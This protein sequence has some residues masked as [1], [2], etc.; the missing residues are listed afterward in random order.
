[1]DLG[2]ISGKSKLGNGGKVKGCRMVK[3]FTQGHTQSG[4]MRLLTEGVV[5]KEIMISS[6]Y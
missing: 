6:F 3:K 2:S 1:M 4:L 5:L